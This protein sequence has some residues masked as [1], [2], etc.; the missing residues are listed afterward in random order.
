M[1]CTMHSIFP[2][3]YT[4]KQWKRQHPCIY[5]NNNNFQWNLRDQVQHKKLLLNSA[6][7]RMREQIIF[8]TMMKNR[9]TVN[10]RNVSRQTVPKSW[11]GHRKRPCV[12]RRTGGTRRWLDDEERSDD[13]LSTSDSRVNGPRYSGALTWRTRWTGPPIWTEYVLGCTTNAVTS[14]LGDMV[15]SPESVDQISRCIEHR[16]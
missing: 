12:E 9:Q 10:R 7:I 13:R 6:W 3:P 4:V 2:T 15:E 16:L 1:C 8:K 11:P 5:N 14:E